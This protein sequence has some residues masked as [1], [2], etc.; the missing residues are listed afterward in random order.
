M[1]RYQNFEMGKPPSVPSSTKRYHRKF[2]VVA[3]NDNEGP[4]P[5]Q[6]NYAHH[7]PPRLSF[8]QIIGLLLCCAVSF[9]G[10]MVV[11]VELHKMAK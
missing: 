9:A 5:Y 3:R 2:P 7:Y 10:L 6:Y 8:G 4:P 11:I 1:V